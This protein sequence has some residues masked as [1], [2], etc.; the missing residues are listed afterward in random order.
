MNS[1]SLRSSIAAMRIRSISSDSGS[2]IVTREVF[3][4]AMAPNQNKKA[5]AEAPAKTTDP[6]GGR[7]RRGDTE[8]GIPAMTQCCFDTSL[9]IGRN[10]HERNNHRN[11]STQR[12]ARGAG[13]RWQRY[14]LRDDGLARGRTRRFGFNWKHNCARTHSRLGKSFQALAQQRNSALPPRLV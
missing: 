8:A 12:H 6:K 10:P 1:D 4:S 2:Q 13:R 14:G 3:F 7:I 5:R 9:S 11:Q